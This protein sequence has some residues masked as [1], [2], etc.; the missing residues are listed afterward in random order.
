M[1]DGTPT[2]GIPV[3]PIAISGD[4][5]DAASGID[6]PE[7]TIPDTVLASI[8]DACTTVVTDPTLIGES[9][10]D[11]WPL[12]MIWATRGQVPARASAIARPTSEDQVADVLRICNENAIPVTPSGGRSGVLGASVPVFGGLQLDMCDLSG[13]RDIDTESHLAD[14]LP[15][16]F[17]DLYEEELRASG[18]TG[19]HWP[20]SMA[21]STVGGWLACRGAGQ[22]STRYGKIEDIVAGLDV[23]LADGSTIRTGGF[24]REAVGPDLNQLFVGSEGTLGVITGARL[25]IHDA[26][27]HTSSAA[28]SF[29]SFDS[30]LAWIRSVIHAGAHPAVLRLYD[31]KESERHFSTPEGR[32]IAVVMDEGEPT[33]VGAY[34][35]VVARCAYD[36]GG[37]IEDTAVVDH[38]LAS[39]NEV[40]ALEALISRGFIVDTMEVSG[41]WSD[42]SAI[43]ERTLAALGS[44]PGS[45]AAGVHCSHSYNS[46][47]CLYF[48]FAAQSDDEDRESRHQTMWKHAAE[49]ALGAGASLS[50][51]H[52]V[53]INRI[54]FMAEALGRSLETIAD[55]KT[56]LD[57]N[58]ILNPGKLGLSS[59]FGTYSFPGQVDT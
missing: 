35:D 33:I 41:R 49:A 23:V 27:A 28:Y 56:A 34:M 15:G 16:T 50:H 43:A 31:P 42:L 24:P 13:I 2:R 46:G 1:S 48:T 40:S 55:I 30:G 21:L 57:P 14:V 10:R 47:A 51:H 44:E 52:G 7:V 32:A 20:Q 22:L 29:D 12:A 59:R 36:H 6:A 37:S 8:S 38:W 19:G 9:S 53:G 4:T 3:P 5:A 25:N 58:G 54:P 39:R 17:G 18:F 26:P 45:L 11:W